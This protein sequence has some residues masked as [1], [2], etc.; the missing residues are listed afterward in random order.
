MPL[1]QK[2]AAKRF[3]IAPL[4]VTS[5]TQRDVSAS[6][7]CSP[8]SESMPLEKKSLSHLRQLLAWQ[9]QTRTH[10][11]LGAGQTVSSR[12]VTKRALIQGLGHRSAAPQKAQLSCTLQW[13][14]RGLEQEGFL[15]WEFSMPSRLSGIEGWRQFL[16]VEP[17]TCRRHKTA[18]RRARMLWRQ[19]RL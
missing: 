6:L 9:T 11:F 8:K 14:G 16:I 12:A 7:N 4:A 15:P 2:A 13:R 19:R 3:L 17:S 18:L 10:S 5:F 1:Q